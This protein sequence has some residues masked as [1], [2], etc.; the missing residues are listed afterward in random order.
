MW[1]EQNT[2]MHVDIF[3]NASYSVTQKSSRK[4]TKRNEEISARK[5]ECS[6]NENQRWE[7]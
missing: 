4:H 1:S 3:A 5:E 6:S 2:E 7:E